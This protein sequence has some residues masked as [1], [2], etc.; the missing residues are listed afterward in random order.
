MVKNFPLCI[1]DLWKNKDCN[2]N[3]SDSNAEFGYSLM[4]FRKK[5]QIKF[6][7]FRFQSCLIGSIS[8]SSTVYFACSL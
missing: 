8:F 5:F 3:L 6:F 7:K 2:P 4:I 1:T